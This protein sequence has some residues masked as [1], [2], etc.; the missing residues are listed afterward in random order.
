MGRGGEDRRILSLL[1]S[2][3]SN[4]TLGSTMSLTSKTFAY[5]AK[6]NPY[7]GD[8]RYNLKD[9]LERELSE[10]AIFIIDK[11]DEGEFHAWC[12]MYG[13]HQEVITVNGPLT[14]VELGS[15]LK[16]PYRYAVLPTSLIVRYT[17]EHLFSLNQGN[18]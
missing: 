5:Y 11:K 12:L 10:I 2:Y 7:L 13:V 16:D 6:G 3:F 9:C 18:D 8:T 4:I 15:L 17:E 14:F 1:F